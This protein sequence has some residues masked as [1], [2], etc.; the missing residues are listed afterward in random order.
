[1]LSLLFARSGP[2]LLGRCL[3]DA[4]EGGTTLGCLFH[5]PAL[6]TEYEYTWLTPTARST[7]GPGIDQPLIRGI[8]TSTQFTHASGKGDRV[9]GA[10]T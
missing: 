4:A 2:L 5:G 1:M 8:T 9:R 6:A 3:L 7:H 10:P